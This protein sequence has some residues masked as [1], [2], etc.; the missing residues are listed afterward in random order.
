MRAP[1]LAQFLDHGRSDGHVTV[2]AAFGVFDM[3][4]WKGF[5]A[6]DVL[7][8][9]ANGF[10]DAQSAMIDQAQ[11]GFETGFTDCGQEAGHLRP[12]EN[13]GEGLVFDDADF[14]EDGPGGAELEAIAEEGA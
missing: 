12:A 11:T 8:R 4:A 5:F 6:M 2:F 1:P 10:S 9:D 13:D 14:L 7:G 3:K